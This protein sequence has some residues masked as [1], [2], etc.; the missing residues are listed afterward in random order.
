MTEND[1]FIEILKQTPDNSIIE[2]TGMIEYF[3]AEQLGILVLK[4]FVP[5][6]VE[7]KFEI[8]SKNRDKLINFIK[9]KN[10]NDLITHYHIYRKGRDIGHGFD[11]FSY[12]IFDFRFYNN[13]FENFKKEFE[14]EDSNIIKQNKKQYT[15]KTLKILEVKQIGQIYAL[16]I[17]TT[18]NDNNLKLRFSIIKEDYDVLFS[19]LKVTKFRFKIETTGNYYG[20]ETRHG[21][22]F[23][24]KNKKFN[25]E[26][27]IPISDKFIANIIWFLKLETETEIEKMKI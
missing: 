24:L 13:K 6:E 26:I 7:F 14:I 11:N 9:T 20:V 1:F 12:N 18:I 21:C 2:T 19:L 23:I 17:F 3:E 8:T 10:C 25:I 16:E 4:D 5:S 15:Q 27:G 22:I